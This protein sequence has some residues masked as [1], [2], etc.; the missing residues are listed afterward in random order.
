MTDLPRLAAP[1]RRALMAAGIT[2]LEDL[3]RHSE[4]D[5]LALHGLGP[6]A[7]EQLRAALAAR[8]LEFRPA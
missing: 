3:A 6:N 4:A 5:L 7:L 2:R 1:A 8:G